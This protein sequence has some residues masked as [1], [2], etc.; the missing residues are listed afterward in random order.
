MSQEKQDH[1]I[2]E[3]TGW[4]QRLSRPEQGEMHI[5]E[6]RSPTEVILHPIMCW[7][8]PSGEYR[9]ACPNYTGDLNAMHDAEKVLRKDAWKWGTYCAELATICGR[10]YPGDSACRWDVEHATAAHK[11]KAFLKV[12][13]QWEDD[14]DCSECD[15]NGCKV[16][17]PDV[18][19]ACPQHPDQRSQGDGW[20][21]C[22]TCG[23]EMVNTKEM[24]AKKEQ[25]DK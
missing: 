22:G 13:G 15:G 14:E 21:R 5:R 2:A 23:G 17:Q 20:A 6:E 25:P 24:E 12:F 1:K 18:W 19:F 7:E 10:L 8:T 4:K 3:L 9:S 11:A 16:C